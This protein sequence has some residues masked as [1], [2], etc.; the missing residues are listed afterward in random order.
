M[1]VVASERRK[2]DSLEDGLA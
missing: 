1:I 2:V